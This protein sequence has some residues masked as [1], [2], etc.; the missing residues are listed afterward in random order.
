M[1]RLRKIA[2]ALIL[3]SILQG[4]Q[5]SYDQLDQAYELYSANSYNQALKKLQKVKST[6]NQTHRFYKEASLFEG[7]IYQEVDSLSKAERSYKEALM[8]EAGPNRIVRN[9]KKRILDLD[10]KLRLEYEANLNLA[11]LYCKQKFYERSIFHLKE[12]DK[13]S[14]YFSCG[15]GMVEGEFQRDSLF[16]LNYLELRKIEPILDRLGGNIFYLSA[17]LDSS[18]I[19]KISE[20]IKEHYSELE[21][22]NSLFRALTSIKREQEVD[23]ISPTEYSTIWFGEEVS[24]QGIET[25]DSDIGIDS[26]NGKSYLMTM[27]EEE[28]I[29]LYKERIRESEIYKELEK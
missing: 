28:Y 7:Q 25:Y 17:E 24:I 2:F 27:G 15:Q 20:L 12:A 3:F 6:F 26:I 22:K 8:E 14:D 19:R 11:R 1:I 10:P 23:D 16:V 5:D 21:I 13:R 9:L 29:E 18:R 4:C